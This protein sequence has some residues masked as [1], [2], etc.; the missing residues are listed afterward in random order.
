MI[1]Y[2]LIWHSIWSDTSADILHVSATGVSG[3]ERIALSFVPYLR[4]HFP[5]TIPTQH[6]SMT[7]Q[8]V[9]TQLRMSSDWHGALSATFWQV[10]ILCDPACMDWTRLRV[11]LVYIRQLTVGCINIVVKTHIDVI[12]IRVYLTYYACLWNSHEIT[13][14][15]RH[16]YS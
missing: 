3:I 6:V 12:P 15:Y 11:V 5:C 7:V 13:N 4:K 16:T 2:D 8:L 1:W 14:V 9:C 10:M